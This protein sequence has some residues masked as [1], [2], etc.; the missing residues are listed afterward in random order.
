MDS[1]DHRDNIVD[2]TFAFQVQFSDS[3]IVPQAYP[4]VIPE[5]RV[6]SKSLVLPCV[7]QISNPQIILISTTWILEI[8]IKVVTN[9][10]TFEEVFSLHI[11]KNTL[12]I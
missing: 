6:R 3:Y 7:A 2:R 12:N 11:F 10:S 1:G 9:G 4:W 5:Y 8:G